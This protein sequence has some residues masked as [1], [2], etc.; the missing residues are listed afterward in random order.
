MAKIEIETTQEWGKQGSKD[1]LYR[2][3][4]IALQVVKMILSEHLYTL[5]YV[6]YY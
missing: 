4:I 5:R 3:H 6:I 1:T 2:N